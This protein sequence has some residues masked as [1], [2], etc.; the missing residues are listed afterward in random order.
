LR[1]DER[2]EEAIQTRLI[3]LQEGLAV[4]ARRVAIERT[5]LDDGLRLPVSD[6]C[7]VPLRKSGRKD[8]TCRAG[9][10]EE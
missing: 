2:S 5:V 8:A 1:G 4:T 7:R 6:N 10:C 3:F 9:N